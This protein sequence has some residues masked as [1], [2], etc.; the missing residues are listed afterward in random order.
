MA[1]KYDLYRDK[2]GEFRF[3]L[4]A[5]N[6][7]IVLASEGF[8]QKRSALAAISSVRKNSQMD[9]RYHRKT[10]AAGRHRFNLMAGNGQIIGTSETCTSSDAL[11][12][13]VEMV[14]R[15]ATTE[16]IDDQT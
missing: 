1:A 11:D 3:R 4:K 2:A 6:G 14:K 5:R 16:V 9:E 13:V 7:E 12:V 15:S 8:R 10:T